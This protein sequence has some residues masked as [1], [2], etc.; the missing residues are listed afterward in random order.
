MPYNEYIPP[1]GWYIYQRKKRRMEGALNAFFS[2]FGLLT[3][4]LGVAI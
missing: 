4:I 1:E 3:F 2:V